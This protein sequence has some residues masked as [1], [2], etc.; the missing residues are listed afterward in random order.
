MRRRR[1]PE[2]HLGGAGLAQHLHELLLRR[3]PHDG[4]V[5]HDEPLARRCSPSAG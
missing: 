5:D 3:A 4:V 1:D 2:V